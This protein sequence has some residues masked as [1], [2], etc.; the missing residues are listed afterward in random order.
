MA[1]DGHFLPHGQPEVF[2]GVTKGPCVGKRC[3]NA[4]CK[5]FIVLGLTVCFHSRHGLCVGQ[6]VSVCV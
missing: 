6:S 1:V 5:F 2:E 3:R 4:T